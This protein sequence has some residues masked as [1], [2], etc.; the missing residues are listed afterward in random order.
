MNLGPIIQS[1]V[2]QKEENKY[3]IST[4]IYEIQKDGTDES[5]HRAAI[6]E[7]IENRFMDKG[8]GEKGEREINGES[9]MDAYTLIYV[10]KQAIGICHMTQGTQTGAL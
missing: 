3:C 9:S 8:R 4:H 5:V 7:H 6:D 1:E 2:S 10:N